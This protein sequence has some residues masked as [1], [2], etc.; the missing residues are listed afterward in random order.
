MSCCFAAGGDAWCA[1]PRKLPSACCCFPQGCC[2]PTEPSNAAL[3]QLQV[4]D[5]AGLADVGEWQSG[6]VVLMGM[7]SYHLLE[8]L[9]HSLLVHGEVVIIDPTPGTLEAYGQTSNSGQRLWL[10]SAYKH[11]QYN[12]NAGGGTTLR[13]LVESLRYELETYPSSRIIRRRLDWSE[14]TLDPKSISS[15][16]DSFR[17]K[18]SLKSS[19]PCAK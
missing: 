8:L 10:F 7:A 3:R 15:S 16:L 18:P 19:T 5:I 12:T 1:P 9:S 6:D 13:P 2:R 17:G 11:G 14:A 4:R